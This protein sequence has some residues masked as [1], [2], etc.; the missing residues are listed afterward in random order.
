[1]PL[2]K[3]TSLISLIIAGLLFSMAATA[4]ISKRKDVKAFMNKMVKEHKFDRASLN[5][6]FQQVEIKKKIIEAMKRPAEA[7]PWFKYRPIFMKQKRIDQGVDFWNK[8][9]DTLKRAREKYGVPERQNM[10]SRINRR[11]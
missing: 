4:D 11:V 9:A 2:M 8:H 1:M 5:K 6:T 7:K 3:I 10:T